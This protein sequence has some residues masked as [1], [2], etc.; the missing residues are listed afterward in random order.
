VFVGGHFSLA[1]TLQYPSS[2][3]SLKPLPK[4][5]ERKKAMRLRT[6]HKCGE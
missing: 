3:G 4:G 5:K 1:G 2:K 6:P